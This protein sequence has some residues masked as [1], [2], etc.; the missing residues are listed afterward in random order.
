M[1]ERHRDVS[2]TMNRGSGN[3]VETQTPPD[4]P[5]L[6]RTAHQAKDFR[7][8]G[9]SEFETKALRDFDIRLRMERGKMAFAEVVSFIR[10]QRS[11]ADILC[12][13]IDDHKG[14][15]SR[16]RRTSPWTRPR[17]NQ[18]A[19]WPARLVRSKSSGQ[20]AKSW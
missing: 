16:Q 2:T 17:S 4:L 10:L 9:R 1:V 6:R 19:T 7:Y 5:Q 15:P 18:R 13:Q 20:I 8:Y 3:V 12:E 14:H 11:A